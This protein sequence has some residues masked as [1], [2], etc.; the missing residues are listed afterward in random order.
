MDFIKKIESNISELEERFKKN[1]EFV[2][3]T[4]ASI[5]RLTAEKMSI[6]D[7]TNRIAGALQAFRFALSE[8]A[9]TQAVTEVIEEKAE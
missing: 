1:T 3:N 9:N 4:N 5:E 6:T 7:E 8:S 2:S